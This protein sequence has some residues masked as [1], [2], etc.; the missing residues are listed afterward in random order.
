MS[1]AAKNQRGFLVNLTNETADSLEELQFELRKKLRKRITKRELVE[2]AI[3]DLVAASA[4][5]K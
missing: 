2:K 4:S 1:T 5:G 3:L